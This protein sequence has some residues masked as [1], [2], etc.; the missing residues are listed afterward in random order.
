MKC[1]LTV[2]GWASWLVVTSL[3]LITLE[4]IIEVSDIPPRSTIV[5]A[6][7]GYDSGAV[8][9]RSD[10][11]LLAWAWERILSVHLGAYI[12]WRAVKA[13]LLR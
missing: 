7:G 4:G 12:V 1:V 13:T 6:L 3:A 9:D 10:A 5:E 8:S 2:L 11:S